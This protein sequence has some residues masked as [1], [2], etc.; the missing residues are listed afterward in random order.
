[1]TSP[2]GPDSGL[3]PAAESPAA[4]TSTP[5]WRRWLTPAVW[6]GVFLGIWLLLSAVW[7][8]VAIAVGNALHSPSGLGP[9]VELYWTFVW[10]AVG[11][12]VVAVVAFAARR[13]VALALALVL[14]AGSAFFAVSLYTSV[15]SVIA[16]V[17]E[18]DTGPLP[19]QCHSGGTCECP[20]G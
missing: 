13:F 8:G 15:Q 19:C 4:E 1:M 3:V 7:R 2:Y 17:E 10:I 18:V 5:A 14:V 20:G 16:P 9:E 11:V 12:G 6:L